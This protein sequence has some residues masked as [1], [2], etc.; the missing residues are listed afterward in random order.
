M[1]TTTHPLNGGTVTLYRNDRHDVIGA[2]YAFEGYGGRSYYL[3][4]AH[5]WD[6]ENRGEY[7]PVE[8]GVYADAE[9]ARNV[10]EQRAR[11]AQAPDTVNVTL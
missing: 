1:Q 5:D 9:S 8:A 2:V 7:D 4:E 11:M 6:G 10:I 3:A